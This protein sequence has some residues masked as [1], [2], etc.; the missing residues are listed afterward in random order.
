MPESPEPERSNW[1]DAVDA[2]PASDN[3]YRRKL[4]EIGDDE[5]T[6]IGPPLN[7]FDESG[8]NAAGSVVVP[9]RQG[10]ELAMPESPDYV[11]DHPASP[12]AVRDMDEEN[13]WQEAAERVASEHFERCS[14]SFREW[15]METT[16]DFGVFAA[17]VTNVTGDAESVS[18]ARRQANS[19]RDD[20]TQAVA[21]S[22]D[23]YR[24]PM[25]ARIHDQVR[26]SR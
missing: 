19:I 18:E 17:I 25:M 9:R 6:T 14:E 26:E 3:F 4:R 7:G 5:P 15:L 21:A 2:T 13:R 8:R 24:W 23:C 11:V 22:G 20:W 10:G 12:Y 16:D 1:P